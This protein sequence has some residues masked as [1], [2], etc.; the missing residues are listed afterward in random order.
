MTRNEID[1]IHARLNICRTYA[2][3]FGESC[4]AFE[5]SAVYK[6]FIE[7]VAQG[8]EVIATFKIKEVALI[9]AT[10]QLQFGTVLHHLRSTC[11]NLIFGLG[12]DFGVKGIK[13]LQFPVFLGTKDFEQW[14]NAHVGFPAEVTDIL[15]KLQPFNSYER[16]NTR[17]DGVSNCLYI[18]NQLSNRDKH[19]MLLMAAL[20]VSA[21]MFQTR[22]GRG[23]D[24]VIRTQFT[25]GNRVLEY[26]TD[27]GT[28]LM[29]HGTSSQDFNFRVTPQIAIKE[30]PP[31]PTIIPAVWFLDQCHDFIK[32]EVIGGLEPFM[33]R[34]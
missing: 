33:T 15:E 6:T 25:M 10:L 12:I 16:A 22:E 2:E 28:V 7:E 20:T 4:K 29:K 1:L 32:N 8:G 23:L 27:I 5:E 13:R 3:E 17:Y 14:K 19:R 34:P 24:G 30:E 26:G 31:I 11:E 18:L 9:P 21:N